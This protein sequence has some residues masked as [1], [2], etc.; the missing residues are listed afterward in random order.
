MKF[1][2]TM[3]ALAATVVVLTSAPAVALTLADSANNCQVSVLSP[4]AAQCA[5]TFLGNNLGNA[6]PGAAETQAFISATWGVTDATPYTLNGPIDASPL[7][8]YQVDLGALYGGDF[9]VAL[10][11]GRG[12]SLYFF[13]DLAAT[14]YLTFTTNAGFGG[15]GNLDV[16]HFTVYGTPVPAVPEPETYA[17]MLAGLGAIGFIA[18]RRKQA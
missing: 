12:F 17:L 7:A 1:S 14:Q 10:K 18:R 13:D 5:G 4:A 16:S 15:N 2:T 11:Q 3:S 8:G 6:S 9:V